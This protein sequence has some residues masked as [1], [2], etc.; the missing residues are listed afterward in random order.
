MVDIRNSS[1]PVLG[2][3]CFVSTSDHALPF[4]SISLLFVLKM[5][6][7][8]DQRLRALGLFSQQPTHLRNESR[9]DSSAESR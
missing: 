2:V 7:L 5:S 1:K 6:V 3:V 8:V 9:H 4:T